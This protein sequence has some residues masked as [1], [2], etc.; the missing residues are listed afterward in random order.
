LVGLNI[1][2]SWKEKRRGT[3]EIAAKKEKEKRGDALRLLHRLK[4]PG[5]FKGIK[6]ETET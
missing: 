4:Q 5:C 6:R 3:Q 2:L 1:D